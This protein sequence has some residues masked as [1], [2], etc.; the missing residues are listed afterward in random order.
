M[1]INDASTVAVEVPVYL[2]PEDIGYFRNRGLD[3]NLPASVITGHIDFVQIRDGSVYILDYKP[4][5]R[6]QPSAPV[7][8]TIYA[9]ALSRRAST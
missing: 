4:E 3:L 5:A 8:L 2:T 6:R 9:M 1:L 7:Q